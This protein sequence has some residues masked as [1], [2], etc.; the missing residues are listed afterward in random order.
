MERDQLHGIAKLVFEAIPVAD[1]EVKSAN[2]IETTVQRVVSELATVLR[3]EFIFPGR[4]KQIEQKVAS[5]QI[6]CDQCQSVYQ[7][8]KA[9][10][11]IQLKTIM[12]GKID[13]RR[14][15]YYCPG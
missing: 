14:P 6:R 7:Q 5:G 3:E 2:E 12:G 4:V 11:P 15:P 1:W 10:Q 9:G 13:F 8:H